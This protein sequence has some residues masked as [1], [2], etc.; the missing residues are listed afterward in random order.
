MEKNCLGITLL[1]NDPLASLP[2]FVRVAKKA[3]ENNLFVGCSSNALFTERSLDL[4]LPY[5][6][7][8]NI[9][10]KGFTDRAYRQCGAPS[11]TPVWRNIER[12]FRA[13]VHLEI[14]CMYRKKRRR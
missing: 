11:A 12:L 8:I 6:D 10:I 3:K 9:G 1:M 13:G 2:T 4:I 5:L 7:F 14:S